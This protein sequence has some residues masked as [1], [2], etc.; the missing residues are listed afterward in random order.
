[1]NYLKNTL[2]TFLLLSLSFSLFAQ[3]ELVLD[4]YPGN[5]G[6]DGIASGTPQF[7][8]LD[9]NIIFTGDNGTEDDIN[10]GQE[11]WISDGTAEGTLLLK[12]INPG[13]PSSDNSQPIAVND[14]FLFFANDGTHGLELWRTDGTTDGTTLV[15]DINTEGDAFYD[16]SEEDNTEVIDGVMYFIANTATGYGELWRSDGTEEGTYF[17]ADPNPTT[18]TSADRVDYLVNYNG[19]LYFSSYGLWKSD[20]TV[21]GTELVSD[22][23]PLDDID[24]LF[25]TEDYIY[26]GNHGF[27]SDRYCRTDGT[28]ENSLVFYERPSSFTFD[29]KIIE[30]QDR[31]YIS[32][33]GDLVSTDGTVEGT[34]EEETADD[35]DTRSAPTSMFIYDDKLYLSAKDDTDGKINLYQKN[36]TDFTYIFETGFQDGRLFQTV[37][38]DG[39]LYFRGTSEEEGSELYS[40]DGELSSLTMYVTQT[41]LGSSSPARLTAIEGAILYSAQANFI[42]WELYKLSIGDIPLAVTHTRTNV[43]CFG[44]ASG[45]IN[46]SVTGNQEPISIAWTGGLTGFNPENLTAG[47]YTYTV[48]DGVGATFEET[49]TISEPDELVLVSTS[50]TPETNGQSDGTISVEVIGGSTPYYFSWTFG[51]GNGPN[52]PNLAAGDYNFNLI[53][54]KGCTLSGT[55]TVDFISALKDATI[56]QMTVFPNPAQNEVRILGLDTQQIAAVSIVLNNGTEQKIAYNYSDDVISIGN[57]LRDNGFFFLKVLMKNGDTFIAPV[58]V[59]K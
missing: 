30:F 20:G 5:S 23:F 38:S 17:L 14:F 21:E 8:V 54:N 34:I 35:F 42:G 28:I 48:T 45:S 25:T 31:V 33:H 49:V 12:D 1:M 15:K 2:T 55:V 41:S 46:V 57:E 4:I 39:L 36:G 13:P 50:S 26:F 56:G 59:S 3:A 52:L 47:D 16:N 10:E 29:R 22:I 32:A 58:F 27:G 40:F 24:D 9:N 44:N 53:D 18:I 51:L 19:I 37:G 11:L 43:D 6:E 7:V